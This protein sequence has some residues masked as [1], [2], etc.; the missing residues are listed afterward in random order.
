VCTHKVAHAWHTV[1]VRYTRARST[2]RMTALPLRLKDIMSFIFYPNIHLL[3][4][5]PT[6]SRAYICAAP[7]RTRY[8]YGDKSFQN[9]IGEDM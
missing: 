7:L 3:S 2:L 1:S 8:Y 9:G 5:V 4:P 6:S